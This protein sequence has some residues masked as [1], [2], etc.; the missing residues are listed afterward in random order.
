MTEV[1]SDLE[2]RFGFP[3]TAERE[4]LTS[5]RAIEH[6]VSIERVLL[7]DFEYLFT[8]VWMKAGREN[9]FELLIFI[10][11]GVNVVCPDITFGTYIDKGFRLPQV[12][13]HGD[14]LNIKNSNGRLW[15]NDEII[16]EIGSELDLNFD[17][18]FVG[19][20]RVPR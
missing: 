18:E 10:A 17:Y 15:L 19:F 7:V 9:I 13:I 12:V 5:S 14:Y 8:N 2:L 1:V 11:S 3:S 6:D 20:N 16:A 4:E